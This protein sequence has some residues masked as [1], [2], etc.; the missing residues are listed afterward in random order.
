LTEPLTRQ[1]D[2]TPPT[3]SLAPHPRASQTPRAREPV[4][5]FA[6]S[7]DEAAFSLGVSRDY[8][9]A[10]VRPGLRIVRMGRRVIVPVREL[11]RW[12]A[13]NAALAVGEER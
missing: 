13:A 1:G 5:R 4:P 12:L 7:A 6:L 9:D 2:E 10:H 11:E 8:F 3:T